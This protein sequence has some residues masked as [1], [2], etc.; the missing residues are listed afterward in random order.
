MT[1]PDIT[2][3]YYNLTT[4]INSTS[5]GNLMQNIAPVL[6]G[7]YLGYAFVLIIFSVTFLYM[8]SLGA[9][10]T[11]PCLLSALS[12]ATVSSWFMLSMNLIDNRFMWIMT[13]L[14]LFIFGIALFKDR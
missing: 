13:F 11:I 8:K 12:L 6:G 14:W 10:E 9:Y 4:L 1:T 2:Q 3:G 7:Y 5:L